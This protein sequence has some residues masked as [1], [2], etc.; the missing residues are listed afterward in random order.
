LRLT[1]NDP[2]DD[3]DDVDLL[4][5]EERLMVAGWKTSFDKVSTEMPNSEAAF[6]AQSTR[7]NWNL[8]SPTVK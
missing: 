2:D 4:N 7:A 8:P 5:D 1:E 6:C 3:T